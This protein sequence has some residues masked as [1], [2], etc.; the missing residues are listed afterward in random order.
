MTRSPAQRGGPKGPALPRPAAYLPVS[1]FRLSATSACHPPPVAA[2]SHLEM[3]ATTRAA[4]G[5]AP[6]SRQITLTGL[7]FPFERGGTSSGLR[8]RLIGYQ[9]RG[10]WYGYGCGPEPVPDSEHLNQGPD[11]RDPGPENGSPVPGLPLS[12]ELTC[13]PPPGAATCHLE[14]DAS[15]EG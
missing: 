8:S 5:A 15:S 11:G 13:H 4:R 7:Q 3:A 10:F 1:G 12:S 14:M 9:V 2:T 6:T